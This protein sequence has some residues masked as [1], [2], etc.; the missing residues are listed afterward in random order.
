MLFSESTIKFNYLCVKLKKGYIVYNIQKINEDG[1]KGGG[2]VDPN[3]LESL[4]SLINNLTGGAGIKGLG[5][6]SKLVGLLGNKEIGGK[7]SNKFPLL[8]ILLLII[9]FGNKGYS[10][11][12]NSPQYVCC[13]CNKKHHKHRRRKDC[14]CNCGYGGYSS[15][16]SYGAYG[17]CGSYGGYGCF[18]NI[19]F[20]II[21]L[22]LIRLSKGASPIMSPATRNIFNLNATDNLDTDDEN[23]ECIDANEEE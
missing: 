12:Y 2:K 9:L 19:I 21:I 23:I 8:L 10:Y 18:S 1:Q 14:C 20:I 3:N 6:L 5:D 15:C 11:G 13:C 16:G 4:G 7:G 22:L 17:G